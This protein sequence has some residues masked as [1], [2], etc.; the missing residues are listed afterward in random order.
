MLLVAGWWVLQ[1]R[2]G[3]L[4]AALVV[5]AVALPTSAATVNVF[6][7]GMGPFD[8]PFEPQSVFF[9]TQTGPRET[10]ASLEQSMPRIL[11]ANGGDRY[12]SADYLAITAAAMIIESGREFEPIGGFDGST[13]SPTLAQLKDQIADHELQTIFAPQTSDSRIQWVAAHC[14]HVPSPGTLSVYFCAAARAAPAQLA[15]PAG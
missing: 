9:H 12:V 14:A 6:T 1:G 11:G 15:R 8:T 2:S 3:F 5:V 7:S 4:A 10:L 13:P